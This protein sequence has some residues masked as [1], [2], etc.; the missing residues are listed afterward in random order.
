VLR[1]FQPEIDAQITVIHE[2]Q[3]SELLSSKQRECR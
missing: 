2:Q 1:I 3:F